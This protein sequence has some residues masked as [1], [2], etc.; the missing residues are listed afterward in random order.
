MNSRNI[1]IV[2]V[3][4]A[5]TVVLVLS[6][7]KIPAPYAPFLVYQVWE[8]PIVAAFLVYGLSMTVLISILNTAILLVVYPGALPTGPLYNLIAV[9]SMLLGVYVAH[10]FAGKL[11]NRRKTT[12][13]II[14]STFLG[15]TLRVAVMSIVNYVALP[16]PYPIGYSLPTVA[17]VALLP[18]IGLFNATLALYTVPTGYVLARA[19]GTR[20]KPTIKLTSQ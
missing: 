6:P 7:V 12:G 9:S 3:F 5:I 18:V 20:T 14:V 4:T 1:A 8:I 13:V 10:N 15:A 19:I 2:A 16:L 17:A 11:F